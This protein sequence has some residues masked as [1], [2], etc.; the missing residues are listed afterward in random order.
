MSEDKVTYLFPKSPTPEKL[1]G[2]ELDV[3]S[4]NIVDSVNF[5]PGGDNEQIQIVLV[6]TPKVDT[7]TAY[8]GTGRDKQHIAAWGCKLSKCQAESFFGLLPNYRTVW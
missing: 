3:P 6:H 7:V 5:M 2:D 1:A 8:I 4:Y